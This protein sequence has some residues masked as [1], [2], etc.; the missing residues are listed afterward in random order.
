MDVHDATSSIDDDECWR[1]EVEVGQTINVQ[2]VAEDASCF[3]RLIAKV[4]E[5]RFVIESGLG[6]GL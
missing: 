5:Q 3:I 4:G 6:G 2:W 1:V